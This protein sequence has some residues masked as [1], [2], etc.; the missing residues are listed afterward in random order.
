MAVLMS[1][2]FLLSTCVNIKACRPIITWHRYSVTF[3]ENKTNISLSTQNFLNL[4][5]KKRRY[6]RKQTNYLIFY[7]F[8]CPIIYFPTNLLHHNFKN[9][10]PC[11]VFIWLE[12]EGGNTHEEPLLLSSLI[13]IHIIPVNSSDPE[14]W[15]SQEQ[16]KRCAFSCSYCSQILYM[17]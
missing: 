16:C 4:Y 14:G 10:N 1:M 9:S 7:V 8:Q 11:Q 17:S 2:S 13:S 5:K 12:W 3:T 6:F 15:L